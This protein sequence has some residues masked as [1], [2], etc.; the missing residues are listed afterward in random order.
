[1]FQNPEFKKP[2]PKNRAQKTEARAGNRSL[3]RL[4]VNHTVFG[5]GFLHPG[6]LGTVLWMLFFGSWLSGHGFLD[7]VSS[8]LIFGIRFFGYGLFGRSQWQGQA[9]SAQHYGSEEG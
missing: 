8:A 9:T 1:M 2:S 4:T 7:A 3:M 5:S 6:F